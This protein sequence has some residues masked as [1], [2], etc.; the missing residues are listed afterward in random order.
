MRRGSAPRPGGGNNFLPP[1]FRL[2]A[3]QI[4]RDGGEGRE[5]AEGRADGAG[6][7]KAGPQRPPVCCFVPAVVQ[8]PRAPGPPGSSGIRPTVMNG[9]GSLAALREMTGVR[10]IRRR[11]RDGGAGAV[12]GV[13]ARSF[14]KEG[15]A[16][17]TPA[18][19]SRELAWFLLRMVQIVDCYLLSA[20]RRLW[21]SGKISRSGFLPLSF[22]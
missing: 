6:R 17:Q 12:P 10:V 2:A 18:F 14:F 21:Q 20:R 15:I 4:R 3:S 11:V 13:P 9:R 1:C 8:R 19:H 16:P 22:L 5:C 7:Q